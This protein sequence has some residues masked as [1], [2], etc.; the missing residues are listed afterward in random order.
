MIAVGKIDDSHRRWPCTTFLGCIPNFRWAVTD[1]NSG[2]VVCYDYVRVMPA[3]SFAK[4]EADHEK[5]F[6]DV[7]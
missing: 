1:T 4:Q 5:G 2:Q 7:R 6:S 3:I